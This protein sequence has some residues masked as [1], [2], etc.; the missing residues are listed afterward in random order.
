MGNRFALCMRLTRS[1]MPSR[2]EFLTIPDNYRSNRW[3]R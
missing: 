1:T 3:I 2:S